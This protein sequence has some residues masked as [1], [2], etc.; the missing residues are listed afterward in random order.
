MR[1]R[2][3]RRVFVC[4]A[5]LMHKQKRAGRS[6]HVLGFFLPWQAVGESSDIECDGG[7]DVGEDARESGGDSFDAADR[8]ER[9]NSSNE[10]VFDE[11]LARFIVVELSE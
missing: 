8:A 4:V 2:R 10:S 9:H 7:T 5:K 3:L 1:T 11:I 6:R